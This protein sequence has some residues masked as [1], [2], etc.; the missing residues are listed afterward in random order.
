MRTNTYD[1]AIAASSPS[2]TSGPR[3]SRWSVRIT[4]PCSREARRRRRALREHYAFPVHAT[5]TADESQALNAFFF[6]TAW[7]AST[8]RPGETDHLHQQLAA[9]AAGRQYADGR[10]VHVDVH[11][12]LRAARRHW[13]AGLVLRGEFDIWRRDSEPEAGFARKDFMDT[14]RSRRRCAPTPGFFV[15]ASLLFV[16]QVL[17]GIV[18]AHYAVEGQGLYGLPLADLFPYS[19]TRTWHTQLAVLWIATAWLGTGLYVAP[20][21]GGREPRFQRPA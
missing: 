4:R 12:D 3:R 6:W 10:G 20:L 17:L 19:V 15:V 2:R 5:L 14:R 1:P 21:L 9:R 16:V 7:A 13:R 18:T 8:N 11:L